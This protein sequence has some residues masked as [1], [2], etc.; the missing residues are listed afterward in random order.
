MFNLTI[1]CIALAT[2]TA[3]FWV[4]EAIPAYHAMNKQ[5]KWHKGI[6]AIMNPFICI[7]WLSSVAFTSKYLIVDIICTLIVVNIFG[8]GGL[9]GTTMG[10]AISN[11]ISFA[12]FIARI[13]ER[14]IQY[15]TFN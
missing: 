14:K 10:F 11:V 12:L 9:I 8:L 6:K 4:M 5:P 7:S 2:L 1:I 15:S 13:K 3:T